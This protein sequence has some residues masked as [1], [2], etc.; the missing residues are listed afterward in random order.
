[1][2]GQKALRV[3]GAK[4]NVMS[5]DWEGTNFD[6]PEQVKQYLDENM[7]E[8]YLADEEEAFI[9]ELIANYRGLLE[10]ESRVKEIVETVQGN[11]VR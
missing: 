2:K 1:M 6:D 11:K 9:E 7:A 3:F 5:Y 8:G 10:T 4:L